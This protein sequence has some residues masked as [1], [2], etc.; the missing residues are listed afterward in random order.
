[1]A[2]ILLYPSVETY[3]ADKILPV[4]GKI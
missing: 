2:R 4:N 3:K 1:M